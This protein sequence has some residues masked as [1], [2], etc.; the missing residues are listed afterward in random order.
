MSIKNRSVV[1]YR[2]MIILAVIIGLIGIALQFMPG[3]EFFTFFLCLAVLGGLIGGSGGYDE[4]DRRQLRQSY[5]TAFEWLLLVMMVA[6]AFI[7][8][9]RLLPY[10]EGAVGFLNGHWPGLV[11]AMMCALM[12]IAGFVPDAG[13]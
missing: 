8:V 11:I 5:K 9:S 2:F 4:Q 3:W 13:S 7:E 10:T 6:Y 12:G 1:G